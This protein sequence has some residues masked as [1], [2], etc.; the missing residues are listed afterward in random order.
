M[1]YIDV[2]FM[3]NFTMDFVILLISGAMRRLKP[4]KLRYSLAA[5]LGALWA[6]IVV[7]WPDMPGWLATPVSYIGIC[8][9]MC[10]VAWN[11]R[12]IRKLLVAVIVLYLVTW[13]MGGA[14]NT[15]YYATKAGTYVR[16]ILTEGTATVTVLWLICS[17]VALSGGFV[18]VR[19]L[20]REYQAVNTPIKEVEVVF[21]GN[22]VSAKALLDTGN[23]LLTPTGKPVHMIDTVLLEQLLNEEQKNYLEHIKKGNLI[24]EEIPPLSFLYIPYRTIDT[25]NGLLLVVM[26]EQMTVKECDREIHIKAPMIGISETVFSAD[27]E[28]QMILHSGDL[29]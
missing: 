12:Q 19:K 16:Q 2:F 8:L 5:A 4:S 7:L 26:M 27:K 17:V 23:R 22:T 28:Y 6:C 1:L 11:I 9:L 18:L 10:L 24:E 29:K 3:L 15:I 13:V 14:L 20:Y 25:H 21:G